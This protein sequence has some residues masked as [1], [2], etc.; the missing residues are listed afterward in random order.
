M[1]NFIRVVTYT[2]TFIK[3]VTGDVEAAHREQCPFLKSPAQDQ[4]RMIPIGDFP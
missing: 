4:E 2:L 1:L 3:C